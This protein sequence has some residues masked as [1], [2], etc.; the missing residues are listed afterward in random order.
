MLAAG[1]L[2]MLMVVVVVVCLMVAQAQAG[3]F[4]SNRLRFINSFK[5][6]GMSMSE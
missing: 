2:V 1:V 5:V 3:S 4:D 6:P